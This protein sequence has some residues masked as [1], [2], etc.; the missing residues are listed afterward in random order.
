M[1]KGAR[2]LKEFK[3]V[4]MTPALEFLMHTRKEKVKF[5]VDDDFNKMQETQ[6]TKATSGPMDM[7]R[8]SAGRGTKSSGLSGAIVD[9]EAVDAQLGI[10]REKSKMLLLPSQ[11]ETM[12]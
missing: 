10:S 12:R 6:G 1:S 11:I 9:Q 8:T 2:L 5:D 4:P 7:M 3:E